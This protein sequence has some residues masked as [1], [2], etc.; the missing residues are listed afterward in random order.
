[1]LSSHTNIK[2]SLLKALMQLIHTFVF[3][4][5][6]FYNISCQL[7]VMYSNVAVHISWLPK[8]FPTHMTAEQLHFVVNYVN[9]SFHCDLL[10]KCS[11]TMETDKVFYIQMRLH[12][13]VQMIS[14]AQVFQTNGASE[15]STFYMHRLFV[16]A[17]FL[18]FIETF[19]ATVAR[20]SSHTFPTVKF[21]LVGDHIILC[22]ENPLTHI[23]FETSCFFVDPGKM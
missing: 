3:S 10:N 11:P 12:V 19:F 23:T 21:S 9:M 22:I 17:Q 6:I 5:N 1:M 16:I 15:L 20:I 13:P 2:S 7:T 18:L 4:K 14:P 8:V